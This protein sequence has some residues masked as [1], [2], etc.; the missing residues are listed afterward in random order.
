MKHAILLGVYKNPDYVRQMTNVLL[1]DGRYNIS[2][3]IGLILYH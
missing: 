2:N 3:N 1:S